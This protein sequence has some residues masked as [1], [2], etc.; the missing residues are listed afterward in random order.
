MIKIVIWFYW[1]E[2]NIDLIYL[3]VQNDSPNKAKDNS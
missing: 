3:E 1:Q 2:I